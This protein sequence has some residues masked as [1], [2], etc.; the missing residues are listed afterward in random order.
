MLKLNKVAS[1]VWTK[2]QTRNNFKSIL[3]LF[4]KLLCP[5]SHSLVWQTTNVYLVLNLLIIKFICYFKITSAFSIPVL[6]I[7]LRF[8]P[9]H[10]GLA[11]QSSEK[12]S[13]YLLR[14]NLFPASLDRIPGK[15]RPC[16]SLDILCLRWVFVSSW[17]K[18]NFV[19]SLRVASL[20]QWSGNSSNHGQISQFLVLA[21]WFE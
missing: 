21:L 17:L 4:W 3:A 16:V 8:A 19:E 2:K 10:Q 20:S 15:P 13:Y 7:R 9:L 18:I 5:N 1:D 6:G 11:N 12:P 14:T